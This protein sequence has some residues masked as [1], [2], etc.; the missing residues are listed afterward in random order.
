[1]CS[2]LEKGLL[3]CYTAT[4]RSGRGVCAVFRSATRFFCSTLKR[5][6]IAAL[7]AGCSAVA[8]WNRVF[9]DRYTIRGQVA[10]KTILKV[11]QRIPAN[12]TVGDPNIPRCNPEWSQESCKLVLRYRLST[13]P[14]AFQDRSSSSA[15]ESQR[16]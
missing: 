1:M 7:G 10:V 6:I 9:L 8:V 5:A 3:K 15:R 14:Q 4:F 13:F 16:C 2:G 11:A 12:D